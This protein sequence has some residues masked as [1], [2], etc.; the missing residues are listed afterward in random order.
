MHSMDFFKV[1]ITDD[2]P[3]WVIYD[4]N[5][6]A[7]LQNQIYLTGKVCFSNNIESTSYL[8]LTNSEFYNSLKSYLNKAC[9]GNVTDCDWDNLIS[10]YM[11]PM[12]LTIFK[13]NNDH[14]NNKTAKNF[15][16]NI[17]LKDLIYQIS[18]KTK[19]GFEFTE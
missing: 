3:S 19:L 17:H 5:L 18:G 10:F 11:Y 15:T 7:Y 8:Y 6:T 12:T 9:N 14:F 4:V 1:K 2:Y 13:E 16:F